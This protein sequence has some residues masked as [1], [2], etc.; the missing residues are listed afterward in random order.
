MPECLSKCEQEGYAGA[1]SDGSHRSVGG[2]TEDHVVAKSQAIMCLCSE[3]V[4]C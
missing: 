1:V 3:T 2:Q 4:Q